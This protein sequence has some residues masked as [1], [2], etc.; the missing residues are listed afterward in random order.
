MMD[1][2]PD[3]ID[4][5]DYMTDEPAEHRVLPASDWTKEVIDYFHK[6]DDSPKIRLPWMKTHADFHLRHSEVSLWAGINGHGKSQIIGQV[7]QNACEQG[8]KVAVASLEMR[9]A[10][11]MAR[12]SRQAYGGDLPPSWYIEKFG[13]WT[14]GRLWLYDHM[15]SSNPRTMAA[16][17][18]YA[19]DKFGVEHFVVDNLMKVIQGEDDYN[20]QKDFVNSLCTIAK[21][22]GCHIHLVLHIKKLKNETDIPNKFDIKGSGAITDLVDNVFIVWRNKAKE[23]AMRMGEEYSPD[24][25][26]CLLILDKQRHGETEGRYRLFFDRGSMQYVEDRN[27]LPRHCKAESGVSI[28]EVEF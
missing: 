15:G 13:K 26:D 1:L 2:I 14:D 5:S 11:T 21:D 24:D 12:M 25:P 17:I 7:T 8:Q 20:Q 27:D 23:S 3:T 28:E 16:V 10:A 22:T 9:P 19:V 6:P 4:L 18:R